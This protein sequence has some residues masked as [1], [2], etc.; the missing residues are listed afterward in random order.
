MFDILRKLI[1]KGW[2]VGFFLFGWGSLSNLQAQSSGEEPLKIKSAE[3]AVEWDNIFESEIWE[4]I[5]PLP[6]VQYAPDYRESMSQETEIRLIQDENYLYVYG[7]MYDNPEG[8]RINSLYRDRESGDD[9][10]AVVLDAFN[11]SETAMWFVVNPAGVRID[12]EVSNDAE[13]R[14]SINFDWDTFW[15]AKGRQIDEGWEAAMRIPFSSLGFQ[16]SEDNIEM[17]LITY[18]LIAR[19]NERQIFPDIPPDWNRGFAKPS[20]AKKVVLNDIGNQNPVYITPYAL[21]GF[22]QTSELAT[23]GNSYTQQNDYTYEPGLDI[24]YPLSSNLTL[25]FTIN[26]DFAQ[27]E[28][29]DQQLDL[30]RFDIFLPEKRQ[31]F[32]ERSNI[33]DFNTGGPNRLFYSRRIGLFD[34]EPVRILGGGRLAGRIGSWD[35]GILNM[36]TERRSDINLPSENFG[37][38]RLRRTVFNQYSYAGGM[39]T[40]RLGED[41][42]YNTG[43]GLD[44]RIRVTGD[45]Y[46]SYN[47]AQTFDDALNSNTTDLLDNSLLRL[48]WSR[49]RSEGFN[50]NFTYKRTGEHYKP[51]MGFEQR[52]FYTM[53]FANLGYGH[54]IDGDNTLRRIN[55]GVESFI[56]WRNEDGSVESA[57]LE[58]PLSFEFDSGASISLSGRYWYEDLRSSLDFSNDVFVPIGSYHFYGGQLQYRMA[59]SSLLRSDFT[60]GYSSFYDGSR[61]SLSMEPTWNISRHFEIGGELETS[62]LEFPE[63]N[64]EMDAYVARFRSLFSLD[65]HLSLQ[66]LVQYDN[67]NRSFLSN[68][69]F[70]YNFREGNDLWIV[71]NENLNTDIHHV[72]PALPRI[73]SRTLMIKYT[74]T[75][76]S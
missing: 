54:F 4:G 46:F 36:Q 12:M 59:K 67:L 48:Q 24:R 17:G 19:D 5:E 25:D 35:V 37:V 33:F 39:V 40:S 61:I 66:A 2:C 52:D 8:V 11:D 43:V 30:E 74:H 60:A 71:Y 72:S 13:G 65:Q 32:Q 57:N 62:Y 34:N 69:R 23:D 45:E 53:L 6:L 70:R 42:S 7:K 10:F 44:G 31:F 73:E 18:R 49:Q 3:S 55:P 64:Q 41:G 29:D 75:F 21:G 63:R 56:T 58:Q 68:L 38:I 22:N 26:T 47:Y 27:V 51:E 50:Y 28:A 15:D 1:L 16:R 76:G 9:L 20:Q 14:G